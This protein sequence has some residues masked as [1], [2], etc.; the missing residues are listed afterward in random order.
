MSVRAPKVRLTPLA[1]F[2]PRA[3]PVN[4]ISSESSI[5]R[6]PPSVLRN[7]IYYEIE[8]LSPRYLDGTE[9]F[10]IP[11]HE[12]VILGFLT[13]SLFA[14]WV[15]GLTAR[16]KI[17]INEK[18]TYNNFPFPEVSKRQAEAI[19]KAVNYVFEARAECRF[20]KLADVYTPESMPDFLL[21]AHE[22]L[23]RL[24]YDIMGIPQGASSEE[25]L[26]VL[27]EKWIEMERA[28]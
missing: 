28:S 24:L 4:E 2:V 12:P 18:L 14:I 13:S 20:E 23:D 16:S 22:N 11:V 10:I 15:K 5:I 27:Y 8:F 3:I 17:S 25:V 6:V 26:M 7:Q 9:K 21:R 1:K 19:D